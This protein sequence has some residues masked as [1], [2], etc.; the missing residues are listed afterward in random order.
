[1]DMERIKYEKE[2][3]EVM[4]ASEKECNDLRVRLV[5]IT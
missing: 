1:M 2:K 5:E 4:K 3:F